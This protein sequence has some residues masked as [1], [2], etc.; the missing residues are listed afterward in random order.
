[1]LIR[2]LAT[3]PHVPTVA[4]WLHDQ[5]WGEDGWTLGATADFLAAATGPAA[6]IAFV[7]LDDAGAPLGT[8]TLDID[9]L[10]VRPD[11]TPWLASVLVAPAARGHGVGRALVRHIEAAAR[12]LGHRE[13]WL[14]TPDA[15]GFYDRLGWRPAGAE[16]WHDVRVMLMRRAL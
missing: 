16:R 3:T 9:D 6:P 13:L 15:A 2:P 1:M 10:A 7:A 8:A 12:T 4:R 5:W 11:L 14:Y